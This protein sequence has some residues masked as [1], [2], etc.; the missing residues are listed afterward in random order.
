[1]ITEQVWQ[2]RKKITNVTDEFRLAKEVFDGNTLTAGVYMA[3]YT[4]N[5]AWSLDSNVLMNNVP[6]AS[7]IILQG[8]AGRKY[9]QRDESP[10][11]L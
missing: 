5:D 10:R 2:V 3:H 1:M 8:V 7:P 6:N 4:D 11:H 9:L